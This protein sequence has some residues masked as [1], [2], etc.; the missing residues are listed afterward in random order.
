MSRRVLLLVCD[1]FG[2]GGAPDAAAYGD[3]GSDTLGNT[4]RA[5]GGIEAPN[6]GSLGLGHLTAIE[7]VAA[8][9]SP[10]TAY[11]ALVE[12][13]AGKDTTT[14]HWEIAGVVLDT[15]FPLYPDGFPPEVIGP[16]MA[17]I[18]HDVLGNRA[19]SGTEIIEELGEE[20]L[21]TGDPIVY[22]SG[23][24]VFQVATH[25]D[26]VSL[27]ELYEWCRTARGLLRGP[28]EVGR[29]IARPFEGPPGAFVRR[30]ERRDYS[31]PPPRPTLL[32]QVR[33]AEVPVYGVG[34]IRD[35]F[36]ERGLSEATYSESNDDGVDKTLEYLSRS[37][38]SLVVA[39]LVDFDSKYGHR[40]DPEGYARCVEAFDVR[41]PELLDGLGE[42]GVMFLTGDHGCDPTTP[43]TDHSRERTPCLVAGLGERAPVALGDRYF[44]DLGATIGDA[45]GVRLS[46]LAGDSFAADLGLT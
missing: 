4:S 43:P 39:N 25:V 40:N 18:D 32:E 13:S 12:R 27:D 9:A 10:G 33:G 21:R 26:V 19:A 15:P 41:I 24:S 36:V 28:N 8:D 23:D 1:S 17:A 6:L 42:D 3:E 38:P 29:V 22:T 30:P 46:D 20:H 44:S 2:V 35:I 14:G 45:L 11:G 37:G 5:A 34:K 7:G 31:I 16:F